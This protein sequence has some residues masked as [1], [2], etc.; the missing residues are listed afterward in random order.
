LLTTLFNNAD[1]VFEWPIAHERADQHCISA[2]CA[3]SACS[4][5]ASRRVRSTALRDF[6][7]LYD[8]SGW[9]RETADFET[10]VNNGLVKNDDL[11]IS[12]AIAASSRK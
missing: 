7:A 12:V 6:D 5:N 1:D 8:R 11:E 4:A 2:R 9:R 10:A 3:K